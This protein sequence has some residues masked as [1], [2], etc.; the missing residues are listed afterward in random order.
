MIRQRANSSAV[1]VCTPELAQHDVACEP[2]YCAGA[3]PAI[4]GNKHSGSC[5]VF[6][7]AHD[8]MKLQRLNWTQLD[9]GA[10]AQM[11]CRQQ[12]RLKT[13]NDS[14]TGSRHLLRRRASIIELC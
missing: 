5:N 14:A 6:L 12:L 8:F 9:K 1:S 4:I 2:A 13:S 3:A 7:L 10:T 11:L